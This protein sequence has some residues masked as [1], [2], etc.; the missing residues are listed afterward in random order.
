MDIIELT[1]N[2]LQE[3]QKP[4]LAMLITSKIAFLALEDERIRDILKRKK[5]FD[6]G[7]FEETM[8]RGEQIQAKEIA[9]RF[10]VVEASTS[11]S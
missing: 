6:E 11:R 8:N 2:Q 10:G 7:I 1:F 4:M 3:R 9:N 5:F